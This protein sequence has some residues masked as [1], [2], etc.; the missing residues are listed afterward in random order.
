MKITLKFQSSYQFYT[1]NDL[2]VECGGWNAK[3]VVPAF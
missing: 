2:H 1:G 3:Y